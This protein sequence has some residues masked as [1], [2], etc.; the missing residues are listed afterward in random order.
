MLEKLQATGGGMPQYTVSDEDGPDHRK[1]FTVEVF[2]CGKK[3]GTGL[4]DS[5]K[6]AE[7]RAAERR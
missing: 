4:G 6:S 5:K 3:M 2:V 7:Q 1:V